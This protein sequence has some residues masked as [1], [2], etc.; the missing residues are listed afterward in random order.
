MLTA[1]SASLL[2]S[3]PLPFISL[4]LYR[5]GGD[6]LQ[7]ASP[8]NMRGEKEEVRIVGEKGGK[9]GGISLLSSRLT[10]VRSTSPQWL[11]VQQ[12]A[13]WG[14]CSRVQIPA[15]S[16]VP[17]W[18]SLPVR[19]LHSFLNENTLPEKEVCRLSDSP[20]TVQLSVFGL[21]LTL[22]RLGRRS[23]GFCS[24]NC[25]LKLV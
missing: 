4:L 25:C 24:A 3:S 16:M 19:G 18:S 13:G 20:S 15:H 11:C 17:C 2:H 8:G 5:A 1:I 22:S 14:T 23:W 6:N 10:A 12:T 21:R 9:G 7:G